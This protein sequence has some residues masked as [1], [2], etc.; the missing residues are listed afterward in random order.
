MPLD[1]EKVDI[2]G[3]DR[4]LMR[5]IAWTGMAKWSTQLV[6]WGATVVLARL[7]TPEAFGIVSMATLYIGFV[8]LFNEMGIGSAVVNMRDLTPPEI[9][10]IHTVSVGLGLAGFV[11]AC[12]MAIP[13]GLIFHAKEVPP[14]IAVLG[15]SFI[16][17]AFKTVP[18]ALLQRE[19]RFKF[20][21]FNEGCQ[22]VVMATSE[23]VLAFLG[24]GYWSLVLG[25][26]IGMA[27]GATLAFSWRPLRFAVPQFAKLK[28]VT[29]FTLNLLGGRILWY[30]YSNADFAV[31]GRA[32]GKESLG[33]YQIAWNFSN[34][35]LRKITELITRVTPSAFAAVQQDKALLRRYILNITE[36][37]SLA[38]FPLCVGITLVADDFVK[39]ALG[40]QWID[41]IVP[42]RL[43][44]VYISMRTIQTIIPQVVIAL[45]DT[46]FLMMNGVLA[47]CVMPAAFLIGTHW[48]LA[49][50]G[51]AWMIAY[52][53]VAVPMYVKLYRMIDLRAGPYL[54]SIW[55]A[56]SGVLA[57]SVV[58]LL[59]RAALSPELALALRLAIQVAAGGLTYVG[60][61]WWMHRARA[62]AVWTAMRALRRPAVGGQARG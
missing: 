23:V 38:T 34:L 22:A 14:V 40:P 27:A 4:S 35:P 51:W 25:E 3:I 32:M 56:T 21:A 1:D 5:G 57:M 48:G 26:L 2:R 46:R 43:L 47:I 30:V 19:F 12:A 8:S 11:V 13:I 28:R 59:V 31:V 58:V 6:T 50:V 24:F 41:A 39:L 42:L 45:G 36:G 61:I 9:R 49:G 53:I 37:L 55:P 10:Q 62:V 60:T 54:R 7:L 18:V 16:V 15:L 20:L 29:R 52:P 33:I 17:N 44:S